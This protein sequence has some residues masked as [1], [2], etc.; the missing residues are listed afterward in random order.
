MREALDCAFS[1]WHCYTLA[2][3]TKP[4]KDSDT[5]KEKERQDKKTQSPEML[6]F[7][8]LGH[9]EYIDRKGSR[10]KWF[11]FCA[12]RRGRRIRRVCEWGCIQLRNTRVEFIGLNRKTPL[13]FPRLLIWRTELKLNWVKPKRTA[14][15]QTLFKPLSKIYCFELKERFLL[16][17]MYYC[18]RPWAMSPVLAIIVDTL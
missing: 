5:E 6:C 3:Y 12:W 2:A 18:K 8:F 10:S 4:R 11:G 14:P 7:C 1:F 13:L 17:K 9:Q 15:F 16:L